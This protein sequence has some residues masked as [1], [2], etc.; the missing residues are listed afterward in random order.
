MRKDIFDLSAIKTKFAFHVASLSDLTPEGLTSMTAFILEL[1]DRIKELAEKP[2]KTDEEYAYIDQ[3]RAEVQKFIGE[4]QEAQ[5]IMRKREWKDT[6]DYY[7][8]LKAEAA[9]GDE[10]AKQ[11]LKDFEP[12]YLE[13]QER[14]KEDADTESPSAQA[15]S[16]LASLV[17]S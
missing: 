12:V 3:L 17:K 1:G 14:M 2:D 7:E 5:I 8:Q 6:E 11:V 9:T 4:L 13:M 15:A 10:N 16:L